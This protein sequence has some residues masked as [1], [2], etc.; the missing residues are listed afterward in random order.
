MTEASATP[1]LQD[2]YAPQN[3]CFGCGPANEQGLRIKSRVEGDEVVA[4]F[5]PSPHHLAFDGIVNGGIVGA[6]FDCHC[7]WAAAWAL[8]RDRGADA[9]PCTVTAE[10][11]V[12]LKR[13]TPLEAELEIRARV[14]DLD[15]DR[16]TVEAT[17]TAG[18]LVTATCRGLF[19]AV[20]E[21]H[22]AFHRW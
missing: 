11:H 8:M 3:R 14:V 1:A 20:R 17:M 6:L 16:A 7:N 4:R 19:V 5:R 10:Y 13:P 9:P 12:K 21:G 15:G 18:G 2:L 22:P